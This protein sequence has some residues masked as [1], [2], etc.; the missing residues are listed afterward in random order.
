MT[1]NCAAFTAELLEAQLFGHAKG[2]F[3]GADQQRS[4]FFEQ[5]GK[6]TLFLDEVGEM[7]LSLQTKFLRV[8][9]N[10]EFYRVG[11]TTPRVS[12]AR[13]IAATN[14]DLRDA[15]TQGSF[16][17]DLFH[18]LS[19]LSITVPP[20]R[21]RDQ[22]W[23]VLLKH[24]ESVYRDT[25]ARFTLTE[26]AKKLLSDYAFPGNVREL[27]NIVIRLGAKHPNQEVNAEAIRSE[28][29]PQVAAGFAQTDENSNEQYEI[30][31]TTPGF[32]LEEELIETERKIISAALTLSNGNLSKAAR[33]LDVNRTT[34]YS[35]VSRLG[36]AEKE[37]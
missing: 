17:Q 27:R 24:F 5:A 31:L 33:M 26:D 28:L 30:R 21:A 11:E 32:S 22:D 8:L 1:L 23:V 6:G 7:P 16:R 19:V 10:G 36:L 12:K 4:G 20:L 18:R 15:V 34:L 14:R 2:A 25:V 9:E 35:K 37:E 29:E 13:I 3:T